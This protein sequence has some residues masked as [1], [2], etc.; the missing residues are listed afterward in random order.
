MTQST[1]LSS[2]CGTTP[3]ITTLSTTCSV[4]SKGVCGGAAGTT[5]PATTTPAAA[6]TW[7]LTNSYSN[8]N[9]QTQ[10]AFSAVEVAVGCQGRACE[11]TGATS[12]SSSCVSG[13]SQTPKDYVAAVSF[14][15]G[16]GACSAGAETSVQGI[17]A[18]GQCVNWNQKSYIVSCDDN[19][20]VYQV[21]N[22]T[23]CLSTPDT[24]VN[25][26]FSGSS[27]CVGNAVASTL[28]V[29]GSAAEAARALVPYVLSLA[30][31]MV[32]VMF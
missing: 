11:N 21:F 7:L 12:S 6:N 31:V 32:L 1:Y 24:D 14:L 4:N 2:T 30:A 16:A 15:G 23:D 9:C 26:T 17:I 18:T 19:R 8:N 5:L 25:Q 20:L 29:C 27:V 13:V 28:Y 3:T 10:I 22:T